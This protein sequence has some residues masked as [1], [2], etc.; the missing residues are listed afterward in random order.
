MPLAPHATLQ[1]CGM[2]SCQTGIHCESFSSRV[3]HCVWKYPRVLPRVGCK[4]DIYLRQHSPPSQ[5]PPHKLSR[6]HF[7]ASSRQWERKCKSSTDAL[8]DCTN[9][10]NFNVGDRWWGT[11]KHRIRA[12]HICV[13]VQAKQEVNRVM[14]VCVS[15][16][17]ILRLCAVGADVK[18]PDI[19][20]GRISLFVFKKCSLPT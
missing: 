6:L 13:G 11:C 7:G 18:E 16:W 20:W 4:S 3:P 2:T 5:N 10:W 8:P 15:Q 17:E 12:L 14:C 9:R 19:C 1:F